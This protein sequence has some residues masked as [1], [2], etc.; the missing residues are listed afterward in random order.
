MKK[1]FVGIDFGHGETTV[2]RVPGYNGMPV[3]QIPLTTGT[4]AADKKVIS[5]ICKRGGEWSLVLSGLD[6]KSDELREGFKGMIHTLSAENKESLKIFAQLIFEAV[7]KNDTD[8]EYNPK[9]GKRNFELGIACPTDWRHQA[10]HPG[11]CNEYLDFFRTE[12]SLPVDHCIN[13]SDAAFFT[14]FREYGLTD[15]VFVI[16]LGSSTIDFTTFVSSKVRKDLC[17]GA[18]LGAHMIE[19]TLKSYIIKGENLTNLR[20]VVKLRQEA[21]L[22]GNI[23]SALSLYIRKAKEEYYIQRQEVGGQF[24]INIAKR[25]LVPSLRSADNCIFEMLDSAEYDKIIAPY[26]T[27]LQNTIMQAKQ[28]LANSGVTPTRVLLSGGACRMPFFVEMVEEQFKGSKIDIDTQPEC[29]VSNGVALFASACADALKG[30]FEKLGRV[31]Y[32]SLYK[33][34]DRNATRDAVQKL[35]PGVLSEIRG[36]YDKSGNTIRDILLRFMKGLNEDNKVFKGLVI[37]EVTNRIN[38]KVR[39]AIVDAFKD[40]FGITVDASG[41]SVN[42]ET[43]PVLAFCENDFAEGEGVFYRS[44]TNWI[45]KGRIYWTELLFDWAQPRDKDDRAEV[46]YE[47]NKHLTE[48]LA[49]DSSIVYGDVTPIAELVKSQAI[50]N[51]QELF[52]KFQLFEGTYKS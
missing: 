47:V 46:A 6:Y 30:V 48:F 18:N 40:V 52:Y 12:C 17:W 35:L 19:D 28:R 16:D 3:S 24:L 49:S 4:N 38:A 25:E 43:I 36:G 1:Y 51:A 14:K 39:S 8:L 22:R 15:S 10:T 23:D 45:L 50:E 5:A 29:V 9:T 2:S 21:S 27:A 11:A 26:V 32:A 7:M 20:E 34:A 33:D 31:D 42:L 13:E 37:S 41:A 44:F